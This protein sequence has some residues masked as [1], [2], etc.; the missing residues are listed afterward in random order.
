MPIS[1]TLKGGSF[2]WWW[3]CCCCCCRRCCVSTLRLKSPSW[4]VEGDVPTPEFNDSKVTWL[5]RAQRFKDGSHHDFPPKKSKYLFLHYLKR[6]KKRKQ[7][8]QSQPWGLN[9][10]RQQ[11]GRHRCVT[12]SRNRGQGLSPRVRPVA[13]S[14]FHRHVNDERFPCEDVAIFCWS[15]HVKWRGKWFNKKQ[16]INSIDQW[17]REKMIFGLVCFVYFVI[18]A[19]NSQQEQRRWSLRC[20]RLYRLF[21][22]H[23]V[24]RCFVLY[25]LND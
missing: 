4:G 8:K 23:I 3:W 9:R 10:I 24:S 5:Q 12:S 20:P 1:C 16:Q 2:K 15:F 13:W 14:W 19:G 11:H 7:N 21:S 25:L 18:S 17:S 22:V 6:T